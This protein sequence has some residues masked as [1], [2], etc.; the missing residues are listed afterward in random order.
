MKL[1]GTYPSHFTRKVR[2]VLQELKLEYD[3]E[4]LPNIMDVGAENFANN[5]LHM[6]PVLVD[7]SAHLIE[8]DIICEYLIEK[9]GRESELARFLPCE[10][11]KYAD[12]KRLAIMNGAM[13]SGVKLIRAKRSNIPNYDEYTFFKQEK[14]SFLAALEWLNEDLGSHD[15][16]Y[17]GRFTMLDITLMCLC[18][19][20]VFREVIPNLRNYPNLQNFVDANHLRPS[21]ESTHPGRNIS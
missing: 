8:S 20:A 10:E 7:G 4:V 2:V 14:A 21:L 3:F 9:Y 6:Y 12:L 11:N 13:A 16:Y 19:W 15:S 1:Y 18:E 17:I 5:P